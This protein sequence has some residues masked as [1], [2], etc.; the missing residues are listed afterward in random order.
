MDAEDEGVA[1]LLAHRRRVLRLLIQLFE[2]LGTCTILRARV[3]LAARI[4]YCQPL[5]DQLEKCHIL[6]LQ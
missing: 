3:M 5:E 4:L 6:D 1:F 2:I